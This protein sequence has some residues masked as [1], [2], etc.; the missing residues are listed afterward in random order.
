M[1]RQAAPNEASEY[2]LEHQVPIN[3]AGSAVD[4][5]TRLGVAKIR[6][7]LPAAS[8]SVASRRWL[9]RIDTRIAPTLAQH[10]RKGRGGDVSPKTSG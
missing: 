9:Q 6:I 7:A 8:H 10:L 2:I 1:S 3:E 4:L 5:C